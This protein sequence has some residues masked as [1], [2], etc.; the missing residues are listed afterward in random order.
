M[1]GPQTFAL[2]DHITKQWRK[3]CSGPGWDVVKHMAIIDADSRK[4]QGPGLGPGQNLARAALRAVRKTKVTLGV[5]IGV[6]DEHEVAERSLGA[7][8]SELACDF[9]SQ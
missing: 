3:R 5:V 9:R 7:D 2:I 1:V 8:P 6:I 4:C